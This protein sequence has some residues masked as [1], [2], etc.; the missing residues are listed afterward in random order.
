MAS[1]SRGTGL[2]VVVSQLERSTVKRLLRVFDGPYRCAPLLALIWATLVSF[3]G[4]RFHAHSVRD[5]APN[6]QRAPLTERVVLVV[7]DGLR[8]DRFSA[9]LPQVSAHAQQSGTLCTVECPELTFTATGIY[10]LGTGAQPTLALLPDNFRARPAEVDSLPWA[11][12]RA[13]GRTLLFG[14]S[15]WLDLFGAHLESGV[16]ERDQ[17]PFASAK[18]TSAQDGL[19]AAL[20]QQRCELCIWHDPHFDKLGH[21]LGIFSPEYAKY[22]REVDVALI[23]MIREAGPNTTW[24]I[25]SDHGMTDSGS[26][27]G[28]QAQSRS[29]FLAGLGAG[30]GHRECPSVVAQRDIPDLISV[31]LGAPMPYSSLGN[32]PDILSGL[33]SNQT[34][35]L[36]EEQLA[37]RVRLASRLVQRLDG[38]AAPLPR[39][40]QEAL[41]IIEQAHRETP[42]GLLLLCLL[43]LLGSLWLGLRLL[44]RWPTTVAWSLAILAVWGWVFGNVIY[45]RISF[46]DAARL[47]FLAAFL[48]CLWS[49]VSRRRRDPMQRLW[50]PIGVAFSVLATADS[51]WV[52]FLEPLVL[53]GLVW[54]ITSH[55]SAPRRFLSVLLSAAV[56]YAMTLAG[57]THLVGGQHAG[58]SSGLGVLWGMG[59]GGLYGAWVHAE[60]GARSRFVTGLVFAGGYLAAQLT[61]IALRPLWPVAVVAWVLLSSASTSTMLRRA[62]ALL[63]GC[64]ALCSIQMG[65]IEWSVMLL[66]GTCVGRSLAIPRLR[67]ALGADLSIGVRGAALLGLG[68]VWVV[69]QGS[70][71]NFGD[72]RV[73]SGFLGGAIPMHLPLIVSLTSL[74]YAAPLLVALCVWFRTDPDIGA[75]RAVT[76]AATT[77]ALL[78]LAFHLVCFTWGKMAWGSWEKQLL[79]VLLLLTWCHAIELSVAILGS[80]AR[81][82]AFVRRLTNPTTAEA[83]T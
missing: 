46:G 37:H 31:L 16:E 17:G 42:R 28:A 64:V 79:E 76:R 27:G 4:L 71:L 22:A 2:A 65:P 55:Q 81:E 41:S 48:V 1:P 75:F 11:V 15:V 45:P 18:E 82:H 5:V 51:H 53:V 59:A 52:A 43:P 14:E 10:S 3:C 13:H 33:S 12:E 57:W 63:L 6:V 62:D 50:L 83:A 47:Y 70:Q 49:L 30:V 39:T 67:Q 9:L 73:L 7:L 44:P 69:G 29:S 20:R 23:A 68:Y 56:G 36:Q 72:V 25:T 61:P 58:L 32:V 26:H 74:Y 38:A 34:Q 78:R 35:E 66:L 77:L 8:K 21:R 60:K 24:M 80:P 19:R 54:A 40:S